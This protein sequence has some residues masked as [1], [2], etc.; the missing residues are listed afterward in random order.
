MVRRFRMALVNKRAAFAD[1]LRG[2]AA[3]SVAFSH[4]GL[5]F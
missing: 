4:Y 2:I 1:G 5:A 3:I